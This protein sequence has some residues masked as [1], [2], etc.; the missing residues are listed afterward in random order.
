MDPETPWVSASDLAEYAYCP[1]AYWYRNHPPPGPVPRGSRHRAE[2]GVRYHTRTLRS[3]RARE[4][5]AGTYLL[6]IGIGL[7]LLAIAGIWIWSM[8]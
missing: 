6:A 2:A 4:S 1:R 7:V 3:E 8:R 5:N